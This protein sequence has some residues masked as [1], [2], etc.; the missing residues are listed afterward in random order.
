M[1]RSDLEAT[2]HALLREPPNAS[3]GVGEAVL[4]SSIASGCHS[5]GSATSTPERFSWGG[6]PTQQ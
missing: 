5:Q 6:R 1:L 2:R 4:S 3:P